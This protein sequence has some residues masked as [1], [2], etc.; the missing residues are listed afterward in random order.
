V[1]GELVAIQELKV[2]AVGAT[3]PTATLTVF[4]QTQKRK[5][6]WWSPSESQLAFLQEVARQEPPVMRISGLVD[7][8]PG[9]VGELSLD[10]ITQAEEDDAAFAEA[11][12]LALPED[13]DALIVALDSLIGAVRH[14]GLR[15]LLERTIGERGKWREDY[16]VAVAAKSN[17]HAYPGG[18]LRHSIEVAE[19]ALHSTRRFPVNRDLVLTAALL[20]DLGKLW[21]M[22]H[23]WSA[24]KYTA[25]GTLKGHIVL[26]IERLGPLCRSLK[27][28]E[29]LT[30]ALVHAILAHHDQLEY[31]SPVRPAT[32][33]A[34]A[35]AKADQL[36][37]ELTQFFAAQESETEA[38]TWRGGRSL[39]LGD[40]GLGALV[41]LAPLPD[42]PEER[43]LR[44]M[45]EAEGISSGFGTVRLPIL[46]V[47]AA[48]DGVRSS[49]DDPEPEEREVF[50]PACGADYLLKVTGDSMVGAGI[51]EG[52]L[53][54]IK[55]QETA[56]PGQIV[57][58]HVPEQ[59]MV[60]KRLTETPR[61]RELASENPAY[62]P[63][64]VTEGVAIQGVVVKQ[65]REL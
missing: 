5:A 53:L 4:D 29:G 22:E 35:L 54:Q 18:L 7:T 55:R 61:G 48:G 33:E 6:K 52:D 60:V 25:A 58:A 40:L 59:G 49:S 3:G 8:K 11:C 9:Y 19:F 63:I 24:G 17:H 51:H 62:L 10:G 27:L 64:P 12:F 14:T 56:R 23:G 26:A 50:P 31:G 38:Q 41:D 65:E 57:I 21:E 42:D 2:K 36:S 28:S 39:Y 37:A 30:D 45:S 13:H 20:H 15:A 16:L 1:W 34:M 44:R 46:G 32:A 43:L 47:V